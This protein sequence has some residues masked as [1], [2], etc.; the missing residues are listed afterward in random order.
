MYR[1]GRTSRNHCGLIAAFGATLILL[2]LSGCDDRSKVSSSSIT[3]PNGAWI[4]SSETEVGGA[5]GTSFDVTTVFLSRTKGDKSKT[6]VLSF[7]HEYGSMRI[8][9]IWQDS[10]HLRVDYGGV[11]G[12]TDIVEPTFVAIKCSDVNISM[13]ALP[14]SQ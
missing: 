4:A 1:A 7:S 2:C 8:K 6:R 12:K 13:E 10:T 5:F 9:L 11:A 3:S 14:N